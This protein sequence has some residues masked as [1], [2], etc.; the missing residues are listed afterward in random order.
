MTSV[1]QTYARKTRIAID[2]LRFRT[3]VRDF[4]ETDI[5]IIPENGIC[6]SNILSL[7]L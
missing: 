7:R 4:D 1:L 3:E 5:K 2:T 6:L